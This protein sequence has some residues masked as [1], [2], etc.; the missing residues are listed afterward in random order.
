MD[1]KKKARDYI[2]NAFDYV[3]KEFIDETDE[4]AEYE[5]ELLVDKVL[6]KRAGLEEEEEG[7][8]DETYIAFEPDP[9]LEQKLNE[10]DEEDD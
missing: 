1:S 6:N 5:L 10:E 4:E 2:N 3:I 9:E 8:E 7:D